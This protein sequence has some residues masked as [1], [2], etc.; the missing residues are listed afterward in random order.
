MPPSK[1]VQWRVTLWTGAARYWVYAA[2]H[3]VPLGPVRSVIRG[4]SMSTTDST[5]PPPGWYE[6]PD[7]TQ[8]N[9]WWS[10]SDWTAHFQPLPTA[11]PVSVPAAA[12]Y[13][14]ASVPAYGPP[15]VGYVPP[16][17]RPFPMPGQRLDFSSSIRAGWNG[18][19]D[20]TGVARRPDYWYWTLFVFIGWLGAS[21]IDT[22]LTAGLLVLLWSLATFVPSLSIAVRRLR[23]AGYHWG[24]LFLTLVP[25]AGL[26]VIAF[27]CRQSPVELA[28]TGS[29]DVN[30]APVS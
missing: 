19:V 1:A 22:V 9:R 7:G 13:G 20:F 18:Y 28:A 10:G 21:A 4:S 26:A 15:P 30:G 24:Y 6:D 17:V 29:G 16:A 27:L 3:A 11:A 14:P 2:A 25:V 23:D 8:R 5:M 12:A